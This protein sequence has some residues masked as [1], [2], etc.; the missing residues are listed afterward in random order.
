MRR[1][2]AVFLIVASSLAEAQ[3]WG[4]YAN[5]MPI[6]IPTPRFV[7]PPPPV[8]MVDTR[9]FP[10]TPETVRELNARLAAGLPAKRDAASLPEILQ[11]PPLPNGK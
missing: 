9:V 3:E 8:L 4:R 10:F 11:P 6:I 1:I 2:V 5:S 7:T